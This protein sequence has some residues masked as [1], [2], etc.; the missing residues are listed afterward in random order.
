MLQISIT[1]IDNGWLVGTPPGSNPNG[2]QTPPT[3]TYCESFDDLVNKLKSLWPK[4]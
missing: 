2:Q 1:Q 3:V 4:K